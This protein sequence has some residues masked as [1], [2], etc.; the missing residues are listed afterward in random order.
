MI[1]L[2][3]HE[4]TAFILEYS[5]FQQK[6]LS[7]SGGKGINKDAVFY[8][9]LEIM[10]DVLALSGSKEQ[11][12]AQKDVIRD[13]KDMSEAAI[14]DFSDSFGRY[15]KRA[16]SNGDISSHSKN[17]L[18]IRLLGLP[19]IQDMKEHCTGTV[20]SDA[21]KAICFDQFAN[22]PHKERVCAYENFLRSLD[23]SAESVFSKQFSSKKCVA[24]AKAATAGKND[25]S[26]SSTGDKKRKKSC[27]RCDDCRIW[28]GMEICP[29]E[30]THN[31]S[32]N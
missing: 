22:K 26:P 13:S 30:P 5:R 28:L 17:E 2:I 16:V 27:K 7:S 9:N 4:L 3:P 21:G 18:C 12:K 10:Y 29:S 25:W 11:Q 23:D 20:V 8:S 31:N 24:K 6:E 19:D 1:F 32:S 14:Q 15:L